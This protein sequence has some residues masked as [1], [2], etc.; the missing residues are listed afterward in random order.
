[1]VKNVSLT[2]IVIL[3]TALVALAPTST[4]LYLPSLP[5]L[6]AFFGASVSETQLTLSAFMGG[7][8]VGT[9]IYGPVSDRFG[10]KPPLLVGMSVFTAATVA[11]GFASSI[12]ELIILRFVSAIGGCASGVLTR[13]MVRDLFARDDAARIFSYMSAAMAMAP[14]LA[15]IVGG[16]VHLAF[17]WR[18]QFFVLAGIG[19]ALTLAS[20]TL[21]SETNKQMNPS[22]INPTRLLRNII[23]LLKHRAFLGYAL[24]SGF[25]YGGLFSFISGGSFVV[26]DVLGVAP[27]NFGYCFIFVAA[28]FISGATLGGR[29]TKKIGILRMMAIGVWIGVAAGSIGLTL[30]LMNIATVPAVIAPVAMVFFSCAFVFPNALAGAL[31]PFPDMAGTASSVAGSVQLGVGASVGAMVGV[32]LEGTAAPMFAVI[33]ATTTTALLVFYGVVRRAEKTPT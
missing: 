25:S 20:L 28:G 22:A 33:L 4:D 2:T 14:A 15:P 27:E 23:Y 26:I 5:S 13:A 9:L 8:A 18:G 21:L 24:T 3:M 29:I 10:R 31:A 12:E 16:A 1:M 6:A 11:C 19:A 30:A 7:L 32:L 17:G